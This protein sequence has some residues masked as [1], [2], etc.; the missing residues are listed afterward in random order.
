MQLYT[1]LIS[2]NKILCRIIT[3]SDIVGFLLFY[4]TPQTRPKN[5][6]QWLILWSFPPIWSQGV[7]VSPKKAPHKISSGMEFRRILHLATLSCHL[8][9]PGNEA[10][11][12]CLLLSEKKAKNLPSISNTTADHCKKEQRNNVLVEHGTRSK[13][14]WGCTASLPQAQELN[15]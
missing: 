12:L 1:N 2:S 7:A 9:L 14:G 6:S 15:G 4:W 13:C 11:G 10:T 5:Q 8:W 3:N